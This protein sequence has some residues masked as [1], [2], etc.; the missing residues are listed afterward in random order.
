[1]CIAVRWQEISITTFHFH[2]S[3]ATLCTFNYTL[4]NTIQSSKKTDAI[5]QNTRHGGLPRTQRAAGQCTGKSINNV[6]SMKFKLF[7]SKTLLTFYIP[8]HYI[9][10]VSFTKES[11]NHT[12]L[13]HSNPSV[14]HLCLCGIQIA[15]L[16]QKLDIKALIITATK[17]APWSF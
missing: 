8:A 9:I 12:V 14:C 16:N 5:T 6:R 17:L 13:F 4:V 1:M 11:L 7:I 2:L 10:S 15:D 3:E